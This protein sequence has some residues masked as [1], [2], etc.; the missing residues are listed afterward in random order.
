M[1]IFDLS[2]PEWLACLA[3]M[4]IGSALQASVGF[5]IALFVVP[6]LALIRPALIPGPMILAALS[7]AVMM[8]FQGWKAVDKENVLRIFGGLLL[9]TAVGALALGSIPT[10]T[11]PRLFGFVILGAVFITAFIRKV[12]FNWKNLFGA[13]MIS[14]VMGTMTGI[15]GPPIAL[16][17]QRQAPDRVRATLAFFFV[18]AYA[19][20][21]GALHGVGLFGIPELTFGLSLTPGV[22]MGFFISFWTRRIFDRGNG[23]RIA[24]L[25][26][27]TLSALR[28]IWKG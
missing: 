5:G 26:I 14:G 10:E 7:L 28:L 21:L 16:F 6:L 23:L 13:G 25:A 24:I 18:L 12:S 9:G 27:A 20:A 22:V 1:G 2:R 17:Y 15:H 4:T 11:L 19:I 8:S 3:I